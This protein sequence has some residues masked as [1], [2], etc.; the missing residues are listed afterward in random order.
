MSWDASYFA[1]ISIAP[2]LCESN[3]A[4][5]FFIELLI[6]FEPILAGFFSTDLPYRSLSGDKLIGCFPVSLFSSCGFYYAIIWA[7]VG[8]YLLAFVLQQI[9]H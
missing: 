6:D 5:R 7:V 3:D 1:W 9:R 8:L 4:D 2:D